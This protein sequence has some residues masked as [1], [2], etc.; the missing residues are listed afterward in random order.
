[1]HPRTVQFVQIWSWT[2]CRVRCCV[3][4]SHLEVVTSAEN[5]RRSP[6]QR[7]RNRIAFAAMNLQIKTRIGEKKVGATA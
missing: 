6:V 2:T 1:M 4:P 7:K 5:G 3:N